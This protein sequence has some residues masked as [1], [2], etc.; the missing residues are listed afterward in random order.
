[1]SDN[2]K[3]SNK[4]ESAQVECVS[5]V[6]VGGFLE[7]LPLVAVVAEDDECNVLAVHQIQEL[8]R[9]GAELFLIIVKRP[10]VT[11]GCE[12]ALH[13]NGINGKQ[14]W[15]RLRQTQKH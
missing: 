6:I 14:H 13:D 7:G 12:Q 10:G 9:A 3:C 1:M 11:V 15:S 8:L 4:Q 2:R 5:L